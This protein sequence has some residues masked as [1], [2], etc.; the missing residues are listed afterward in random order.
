MHAISASGMKAYGFKPPEA[1]SSP[2]TSRVSSPGA[3]GRGT[4]A[5]SAKS[6]A[7]SSASATAPCKPERKFTR[8]SCP[9]GPTRAVRCDTP[10]TG[11]FCESAPVIETDAVVVGAGPSGATTALLLARRGHNVVLLDRARFPRDKACGE[12]VMPPGVAALRRLGLFERVLATGARPLDGVTYRHRRTGLQVHLPFPAP[13][14]GGPAA[15][16]GV[17]R[18]TFDATLVDA[19]RE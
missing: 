8:T 5:S 17:R 14:D 7:G 3:K 10:G 19:V 15:G 11:S 4:P 9:G 12:G 16:L 6:S 2:A 1:M 18:T 13:P